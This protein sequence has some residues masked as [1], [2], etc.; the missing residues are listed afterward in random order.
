LVRARPSPRAHT[1]DVI[2]LEEALVFVV[3]RKVRE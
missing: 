2:A 1:G 3:E